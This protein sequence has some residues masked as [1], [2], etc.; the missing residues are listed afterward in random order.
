MKK[1]LLSRV[2]NIGDVILTLPMAGVLKSE[3]ECEIYFLGK[4]YTQAIIE[5]S[6]FIDYFIN[7][8]TLLQKTPLEQLQYIKSLGLDVAVH[9]FPNRHLSKL[10]KMAK[11]PQRI[12]TSHRIYHWFTCNKLLNLGRKNSNLHEAQL[13]IKLLNPIIGDKNITLKEIAKFNDFSKI[14]ELPEQFLQLTD[15]SKINIILHPLSKGSGRE[16]GLENFGKL[17]EILSQSNF[18]IF[19]TGTKEE[20][21]KMEYFLKKYK[22]Q[23]IDTTG[24]FNLNEMVAFIAS[25]DGLVACSTGML[26][27]AAAVGI[28]AVGLYPP[29]RAISPTRW[30]PL[31]INASYIVKDKNC[32][33]CKKSG[34][35]LCMTS[36]TPREV[37]EKLSQIKK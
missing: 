3:L 29:L 16:W 22:D 1:I 33:D 23:I 34:V 37:Y 25:V 4:S 17:I 31:G 36:I 13:N 32:T 24:M 14:K 11:I 26:H 2:D 28:N 15:A 30:A 9:V 35:C 10:F 8:D 27:V 21:V 6:K 7:Y 18:K 5:P 20:G 12:G 19:I